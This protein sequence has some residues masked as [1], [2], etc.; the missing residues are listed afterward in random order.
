MTNRQHS[1]TRKQRARASATLLSILLLSISSSRFVSPA[2]ADDIYFGASAG[3]R[4]LYF[5]AL[6]TSAATLGRGT[7]SASGAMDASDVLRFPANTPLAGGGQFFLGASGQGETHAVFAAAVLPIFRD[8]ALGIFGQSTPMN[9][10]PVPNTLDINNIDMPT[11]N[12]LA[13]NLFGASLAAY[14]PEYGYG[15]GFNA[16]FYWSAVWDKSAAWGKEA[17]FGALGADFRFDPAEFLTGRI[18]FSSA[19]MPLNGDSVFI[20]R[21]AEQYGLIMNYNQYLGESGFW[22]ANLGGGLR[23]TTWDGA[24]EVGV[25]AEFIA[26][27]RYFMR[28]GWEVSTSAIADAASFAWKDVKYF[29]GSGEVNFDKFNKLA[30]LYGWGVGLGVKIGGLRVDAAYRPG[31][32]GTAN[33]I[34]SA[35]ATFEIEEMKKRSAEDNLTLARDYYA[36]ERFG[37]SRL[38]SA[39]AIHE[40]STL[41]NAVPLYAMSEAE[42]RRRAPG[43]IAF[44]YGGNSKGVVVPYPPSEEA[45]GGLSRYA[46]LVSRLRTKYPVNFTV[47]VGNLISAGKD[48]LRLEFAG[49]YYDAARFDVLAP[50]VGELSMG[51]AKFA[52]ALKR[53]IPIIVTNLNDNDAEA[54]GIRSSAVLTNS[55]YS[56]YFINLIE[57]VPEDDELDL[58]YDPAAIKSQLA[59]GKAAAADLRVAV[60]H[61]TLDEVRHLAETLEGGLDIIIAGSL[62]QRFDRPITVGNTLIVSAGA[63]NKFAGCLFVKFNDV[64]K[65]IKRGKGDKAA[66]TAR[67]AP[68]RKKA[69]ARFTA[70]NILIPV[71]QDIEPDEAVESVTKLVRAAIA[72][73]RTDGSTIRTRV[74]GVVAHL[75]DRGRGPQAFLKSAQGKNEL[76]LSDSVFNCRR[77]LLSSAGNRAAFIFGKPDDKN[78]KLRMVDLEMGVGKTVSKGKNVLDAVFSPVD[79]FLYYIEADSGSDIGVI[80]KTRMYMN[81]AITVLYADA[82]QRGDLQISADGETLIFASK[83]KNG[84]WDLFALDMSG[85]VA[86]VRLTDGG[87]DHRFPRISPDGKYVAYLSNR[88]GFGWKMDL[89]VYDR[90]ATKHKQITFDTDVQGFTWSDD[91]ETI[92]FS[93]GANLLEICRVDMRHNL[94]KNLIPHPQGGVKSWSESAPKFIRYNDEPMIV[95][96]RVYPDGKRRIY[97]FDVNKA[98][99]AKMYSV[100]EFDEWNED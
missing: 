98:A 78:G 61:G 10:W 90:V 41:W 24:F 87:A 52:A 59:G 8:G 82:S 11:S 76:L 49:N 93:A 73:D 26:G 85:K 4:P 56:V 40:D 94:I 66:A 45:L 28:L 38:Y 15:F 34:W 37:K 100:G 21:F 50:G 23:K 19:G 12:S 2:A 18:Y 6:P 86:P 80:R 84:K 92:Y 16:S 29:M 36:S 57:T 1:Q 20:H 89:W 75:S 91:S 9:V 54:T 69:K 88:T 95:Y 64:K 96:T 68:V 43:S 31:P 5:L 97:W 71:D 30:V 77:P 44:I 27:G 67:R 63:E 32:D 25:G 62:D 7:V 60:V 74:R 55:G 14:I 3:S 13:Y 99:D 22:K 47:D 83:Y 39:R 35:D 42:L 70:E 33:G 81:D 53:K 72:V 65:E 46:A 48:A 17:L 79:N 51:P 58:S